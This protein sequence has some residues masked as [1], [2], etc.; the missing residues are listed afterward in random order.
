[1]ATNPPPTTE[2]LPSI[3]PTVSPDFY[4]DYADDYDIDAINDEYLAAIEAAAQEVV[5]S[6]TVCR[7]GQIFVDIT[8][9][10]LVDDLDWDEIYESIDHASI[11]NRHER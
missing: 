3:D 5:P 11:V 2:I 6:I 8:E 1:M 9:V 4:G 7:N 10:D